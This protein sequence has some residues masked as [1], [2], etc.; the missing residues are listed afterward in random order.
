MT[1]SKLYEIGFRHGFS[2]KGP[3]ERADPS[4]FMLIEWALRKE[5]FWTR[6]GSIICWG[7]HFLLKNHKGPSKND[8]SRGWLWRRGGAGLFRREKRGGQR[9]FRGPP[10]AFVGAS[11]FFDGPLWVLSK[12][13]WHQQIID[14]RR[15]QKVYFQKARSM[16]MKNEGSAISGE[17]FVEKLWR[18]PISW[19]FDD[20]IRL[21]TSLQH[22]S[23]TR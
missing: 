18:N 11:T 1:S 7:Q 8:G 6:L 2:R 12:K 9:F 5:R 14:L 20:V 4:F 23:G 10:S 15:A 16:N 21:M 3:S 22:L 17:P 13:C 19:N